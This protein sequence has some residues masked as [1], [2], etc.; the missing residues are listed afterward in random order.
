[1]IL[2]LYFLKAREFFPFHNFDLLNEQELQPLVDCRFFG[3]NKFFLNLKLTYCMLMDQY[4][5]N[6]H[7]HHNKEHS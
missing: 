6:Q 5:Q 3:F 4:Q 1:M 2:K 7:P